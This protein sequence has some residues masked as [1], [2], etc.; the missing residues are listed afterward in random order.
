M[1]LGNQETYETNSAII[2]F[3]VIE[4]NFVQKNALYIGI[5]F[6]VIIAVFCV[7][8]YIKNKRS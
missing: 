3:E 8:V 2:M 1:F 4:P 5:A 6:A 7:V